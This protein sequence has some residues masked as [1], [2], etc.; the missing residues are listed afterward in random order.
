MNAKKQE[1]GH[2]TDAAE[3][4]RNEEIRQVTRAQFPRPRVSEY[5]EITVVHLAAVR[6]Q[7]RP[8]AFEKRKGWAYPFL[9]NGAC[10]GN[11]VTLIKVRT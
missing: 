7:H 2:Q 9:T 11:L 1:F 8:P 4:R 10:A 6:R 3:G 5:S